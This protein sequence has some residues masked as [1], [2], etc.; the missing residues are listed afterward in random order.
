MYAHTHDGILLNHKREWNWVSYSEVDEPRVCYTEWSK[1]KR[2][3]Y[4]I[5]THIYGIL[6][7]GTDEPVCR[8][9]IE[10]LTDRMDLWTQQGKEKGG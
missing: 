5:L 7:N 8:A 10:V 3:K 2:E 1:T 6:K 4:C 9:G